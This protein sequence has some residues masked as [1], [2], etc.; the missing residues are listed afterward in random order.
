MSGFARPCNVVAAAVAA[1]ASV[2]LVVGLRVLGSGALIAGN[3]PATLVGGVMLNS[4]CGCAG[5]WTSTT[6]SNFK[7]QLIIEYNNECC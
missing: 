5:K 4:P 7:L 2:W 3:A 6:K 1:I